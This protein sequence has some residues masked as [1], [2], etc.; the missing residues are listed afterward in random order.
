V[1]RGCRGGGK[2]QEDRISSP[3]KTVPDVPRGPA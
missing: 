1:V 3:D 2:S